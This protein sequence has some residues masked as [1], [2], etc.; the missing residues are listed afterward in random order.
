MPSLSRRILLALPALAVPCLAR[1]QAPSQAPSWPERPVKVIVPFP[2]GSTPDTAARAVA[3][4]F[5]QVFGQPFVADN[6]S[7]AGG[8]LGTDLVAKATDGHTI[9]VSINGPLTTAPALYSSLPYDPAK[10]LAPVSQLV[11]MAQ[12]LVVNPKLPVSNYNQ[13]VAYAKANPGKLSFGSVGQGSAGHLAMEDLMARTGTEMVHVP[14]RGF[15]PAVLDLMA[16]RIEVMMV[17][18]AAILPQIEAGQARA[19]AVTA[20]HRLPQA[21]EVPTLTEAGLP[22]AESYAFI[23]LIAP[24]GMPVDRVTRLAQEAKRGL[25]QPA[26]REVMEKAGFEVV[27][28]GP[29]DFARFLEAERERWGGLI[30]RLGITGE[31]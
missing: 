7:G 24:A 11:R 14:Y 17:S 16:G 27:G 29:E 2:P 8:N 26:T 15:P 28:S 22:N 9:G 23:G 4:H 1:A 25:E 31:G 5:T 6:R 20:N 19:L 30:R 13:F 18:A 3:A 12:F 10:D 21:P